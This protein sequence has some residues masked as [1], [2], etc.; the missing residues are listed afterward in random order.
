[1]A[2]YTPEQFAGKL[3]ELSAAAGTVA[4]RKSMEESVVVVTKNIT[5][6]IPGRGKKFGVR[7]EM[8]GGDSS[9][10]ALILPTG[11]FAFIERDTKPHVEPRDSNAV[12]AY[13]GLVYSKVNHPGTRGKH[14]FE[15]GSKL[16]EA[17]VPRIFEANNRAAVEAVL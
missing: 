11:P 9:W 17:E 15:R 2:Q 8:T 1:M 4:P 6:L 10:Q 5:A 3:A 12:V 14:P 13:D 16:A 7:S